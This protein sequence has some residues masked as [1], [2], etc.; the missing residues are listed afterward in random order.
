MAGESPDNSEQQKT[1]GETA[2]GDRDPRLAVFGD[3]RS[4]D[5][6]GAVRVDQPTAVF[7]TVQRASERDEGDSAPPEGDARLR[8]AVAAW[9]A[10]EG[11]GEGEAGEASGRDVS[12]APESGPGPGSASEPRSASAPRPRSGTASGSPVTADADTP[13]DVSGDKGDKS[14][15]SGKSDDVSDK[16]LDSTEADASGVS[17]ASAASDDAAGEA[18]EPDASDASDGPDAS[19]KRDDGDRSGED[20]MSREAGEAEEPGA[21]AAADDADD[22]AGQDTADE[23]AEE[24]ADASER[25]VD[26]P[27][28]VFKAIQR[29]PVDQPTTALKFVAPKG[30]AAESSAGPS[31]TGPSAAE[32]S[33]GPSSTGSSSTGTPA[34]RTP[35]P[36]APAERTSKFVPLRADDVRPA[37]KRPQPGP[38]VPAPAPKAT[39]KPA[40]GPEPV[41]AAPAAPTPPPSLTE[42]ERTKQQPVPPLPPLDLLA[43]LTNTPPPPQ[44]PVRT[45]VRRVKIWTPLVVLLLIVFATVQF[46]RPLPAPVL[47]LSASPSYTFQGG[48][49]SMP[50]PKEGQGAVEVEGVGSIGTYGAQKPAP[51]ASVAK[52]MT[53]YVILKN[54]PIKVGA[55]APQLTIEKLTAEQASNPDW[56]V[57]P[58]KE[59]QKYTLEQMLQMLMIPSANNVAHQLARWDAG[60][61]EA[62]LKKMNDAAKDLGM[63]NS[64]Y[65]DPSGFE[66]TTVST[67]TDQLKLAKAVMQYDVFRDI[68]DRPN[69]TLP[70]IAKRMENGNTILMRDGVTGI[71]TGSSTPAGGNLLWAANTKVDGEV[72][73]IVGIVMGAQDAPMVREKLRLAVETYSYG[74]IKSAQDGVTSATVVK[75]GDVVGHVDDG[76]GGLTPVVATRDLKAVGWP[77]LKVDL[78]IAAGGK[79]VPHSAPA[80]T[81]VGEASVGIGTGKVSV[82]VALRT[83]LAEPGLGDKLTRLG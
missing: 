53:A 26:Q 48:P 19:D 34:G 15:N 74:L 43:E 21:P 9:V 22:T 45:A 3:E 77:G 13:K 2:S 49:L 5:G 60:S 35:A 65:T 52:T 58:V 38:S 61:E 32:P 11:D 63:T 23:P 1:P 40:P 64:T 18:A 67:P 51:L 70:G 33:T 29:T 17:A 50:W 4:S 6:G 39:P 68:V 71:K 72:R 31:S 62:F 66:K 82:P 42:A 28:A 14:G 57:A 12:S 37:V 80:G 10:N 79:S 27:T 16:V 30:S 55:K 25:P 47:T 81:V 83:E 69:L 76:L 75:K 54:H 73:R 46:V 44:T 41:A 24:P 20:G 8:A 36:E 78:H 56:S 7:K 59:G